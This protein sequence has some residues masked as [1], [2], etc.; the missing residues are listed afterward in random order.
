MGAT[1][2]AS[3]ENAI[4]ELILYFDSHISVNTTSELYIQETK[5]S[6]DKRKSLSHQ[7]SVASE[8]ELPSLSFTDAF[9]DKECQEW[10]ICAYINKDE[11]VKISLQEV[12][13]GIIEVES[14]LARLKEYSPFLQFINLS[15]ILK[16]IETLQKRAKHISVLDFENGERVYSTIIN[17]KNSSFLQKEELKSHLTFSI[18]IENDFED[19]I[20]TALE[21]I[22]EKEGFIRS[23]DAK[24]ILRGSLKTAI[25]KNN[26][27]VFATPRLSVQIIDAK[28]G[29]VPVASYTKA[30]KKWGHMN[31][32]GALKKAC[33]E[34]EKDLRQHFIG[35]IYS[36]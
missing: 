28:S 8:G 33:V 35:F 32:E 30:Y 19:I 2:Q 12:E 29:G 27:G 21:E 7:V 20:S 17:L 11:F 22:L 18:H 6:F 14:T 24:L 4:S 34:V 36:L 1:L 15:K 31:E 3:R 9:F 26:A 25:T 13:K 16:D 5:D 23:S 10:Y